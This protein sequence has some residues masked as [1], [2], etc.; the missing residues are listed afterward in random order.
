MSLYPLAEHQR[1][2]RSSVPTQSL[3]LTENDHSDLD[4]RFRGCRRTFPET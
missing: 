2:N 3:Q 1:Q 4:Q